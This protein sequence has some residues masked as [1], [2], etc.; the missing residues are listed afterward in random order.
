M[1]ILGSVEGFLGAS[2]GGSGLF[3]EGKLD[4]VGD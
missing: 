1:G 2:V 3:K 4:N